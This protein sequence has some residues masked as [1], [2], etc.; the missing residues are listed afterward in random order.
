MIERYLP[1]VPVL[2]YN[3]L[4]ASIEVQSIGV[5]NVEG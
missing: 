1:Q 4:E 3:E 5:V 2:S